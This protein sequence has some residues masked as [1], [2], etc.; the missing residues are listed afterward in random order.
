MVWR[1]VNPVTTTPLAQ[2]STVP[3]DP[4]RSDQY[5]NAVFRVTRYGADFP[6]LIG[7]DLTPIGT[8]ETYP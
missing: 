6:G 1:Y 4:N 7:K 3:T 8:I 5:M 2:G